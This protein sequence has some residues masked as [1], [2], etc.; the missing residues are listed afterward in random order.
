MANKPIHSIRVGAIQVSIW[1]NPLK[2]GSGV[3]RSVTITKSYKQGEEWKQTTSFKMADLP[4]IQLAMNEALEFHYI[5][6]DPDT[7]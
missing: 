5:K 1:E 7:F 2:D 3:I 4:L 6:A